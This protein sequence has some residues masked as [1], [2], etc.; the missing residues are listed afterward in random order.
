MTCFQALRVRLENAITDKSY[1][2]FNVIILKIN[3]K[4]LSLHHKN[5][6]S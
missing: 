6:L 2:I 5:I 4:L 1:G 3:K